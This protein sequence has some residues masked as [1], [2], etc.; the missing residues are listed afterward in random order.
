MFIR[1]E[2]ISHILWLLS[3]HLPIFRPEV[4][5][6]YSQSEEMLLGSILFLLTPVS[7]LSVSLLVI[8][9]QF[10]KGKEVAFCFLLHE[11]E[12]Q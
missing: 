6:S 7:L 3:V 5:I 8:Y 9:K 12:K 2:G 10:Q 4:K 11:D 1:K